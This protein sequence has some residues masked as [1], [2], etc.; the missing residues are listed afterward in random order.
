MIVIL[1]LGHRLK[2]DERLSTHCGLAARALGANKIIFSGEHD[3]NLLK[4]VND[5]SARWGG[6]F[7]ASYEKNWKKVINYYK[8][9]KFIAC[10][11]TMY[12]MPLKKRI[13]AIR[14]EKNLIVIIGSE[15][16]P[17]EVYHLANYNVAVSSQPHSEVAALAVF[18]HEYSKGKELGKRFPKAKIRVVPQERGKKVAKL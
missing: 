3:E 10:H 15:K 18:L 13:A 14:K 4:S 17:G 1:R 7:A 12:G 6:R 16:V 11:M 9:K 5:A 8:R 2:R